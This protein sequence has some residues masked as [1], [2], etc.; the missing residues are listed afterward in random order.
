MIGRP[1][2]QGDSKCERIAAVLDMSQSV[3]GPR[4]AMSKLLLI[5]DDDETAVEVVGELTHRGY[6]VDRAATGLVGIELARAGD[7]DVLIVD[8]LLPE[9]DGLTI[10]ETLRR[11]HKRTPVLVLSALGALDDR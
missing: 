8:R 3:E 11:E 1:G 9:I 2:D 10:I 4:K 6:L 7:H 5:E